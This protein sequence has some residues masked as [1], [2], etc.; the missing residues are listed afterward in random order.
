MS[1]DI[2]GINGTEDTIRVYRDGNQIGATTSSWNPAGTVEYDIVLGYGP[3]SGGYDKFITDNL[4]IWDYAKTDFSDRFVENPG[5]H[6]GPF[7]IAEN[8]A[9]GTLLATIQATDS[10]GDPLTYSILSG[11]T[12]PD[13]DTQAA[14]AI[15]AA[16]GAITVNDS[17]DLDYEIT[18][19]LRP[20]RQG[21]RR[22]RCVAIRRRHRR[23]HQRRRARQRAPGGPGRRLHP[24]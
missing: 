1:W 14:F 24:A 8:F 3:D 18:A 6:L 11:N 16:T 15:D 22:K 7:T 2:N 4:I 17:G 20:D 10:D 21:H 19:A 5:T 12:D 23:S 9:E 13:G